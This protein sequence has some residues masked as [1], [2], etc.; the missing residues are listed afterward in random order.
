MVVRNDGLPLG[1][2][3]FCFFCGRYVRKIG[4]GSSLPKDAYT[5]EHL[6]PRSRGGSYKHIVPAC[7]GCNEDKHALTLDEYRVVCALRAG[8]IQLPEYKFAAEAR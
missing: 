7:R 1:L 4:G 3:G 5:R 6:V 2:G 8:A